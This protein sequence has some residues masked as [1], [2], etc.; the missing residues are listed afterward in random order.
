M[1]VDGTGRS[2][3]ASGPVPDTA[4]VSEGVEDRFRYVGDAAI[5]A[6]V[7]LDCMGFVTRSGNRHREEMSVMPPEA[8]TAIV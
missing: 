3:N 1:G 7:I 6:V 4:A 5:T 2:H 8:A